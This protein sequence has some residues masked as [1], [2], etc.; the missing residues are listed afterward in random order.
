MFGQQLLRRKVVIVLL[1]EPDLRLAPLVEPYQLLLRLDQSEIVG[2]SVKAL[3]HCRKDCQSLLQLQSAH[4]AQPDGDI[5]DE[6]PHILLVEA[7]GLVGRQ[8][9]MIDLHEIL[10]NGTHLVPIHVLDGR[11]RVQTIYLCQLV[12]LPIPP[13]LL[14]GPRLRQLPFLTPVVTDYVIVLGI[15]GAVPHSNDDYRNNKNR[16]HSF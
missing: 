13:Q 9:N 11:N 12:S 2:N 3:K 10:L 6:H 7:Q 1:V 16:L 15:F 5:F 8:G 14:T 4:V